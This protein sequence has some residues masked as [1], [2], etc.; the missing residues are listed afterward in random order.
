MRIVSDRPASLSEVAALLKKRQKEGELSYEQSNALAYAEAF[1][2][3]DLKEA[4]ALDRALEKLGFLTPGARSS[5]V[6]ILP[7]K[8]DEV[9]SILAKEKIEASE[10][11]VKEI[12]KAVKARK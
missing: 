6:D 12:L 1:T 8:E 9:K 3:L 7:K 2:K 10:E 11:Q 4:Q 5:L